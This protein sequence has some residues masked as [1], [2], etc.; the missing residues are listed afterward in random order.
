LNV[1]QT[2]G[3]GSEIIVTKGVIEF[4]FVKL[5]SKSSRTKGFDYILQIYGK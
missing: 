3:S 4:P 2:P 5:H 1:N